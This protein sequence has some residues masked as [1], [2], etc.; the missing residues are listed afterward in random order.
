MIVLKDR[1]VLTKDYKFIDL[2]KYDTDKIYFDPMYVENKLVFAMKYYDETIIN[3]SQI[4][5]IITHPTYAIDT[6]NKDQTYEVEVNYNTKGVVYYD[7]EKEWKYI[8]TENGDLDFEENRYNITR[9]KVDY[10]IK[11]GIWYTKVIFIKNF[12][13][14]YILNVIE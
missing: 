4:K 10:K 14:K 2:K 12:K 13:G 3:S 1:I 5:R 9:A 11:G 7:K 6:T 8:R